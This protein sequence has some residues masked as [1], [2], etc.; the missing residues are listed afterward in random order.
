MMICPETFYEMHLKGKTKEEIMTVI[1]GLKREIGRLKRTMEH[2]N[3]AKAIKIHPSE[4]VRISCSRDYLRRA[5]EALEEVGGTYTP[6]A[7]EKK[8]L[9]FDSNIPYINKV[10][11]CIGGFLDGY[12]RIIYTIDGDTVHTETDSPFDP[13]P[14]FGEDEDEELSKED[15]LS[16]LEEMHIGEWLKLYDC[17][18]FG[19]HILDGTQWHLYLYFSNGHRPVKIYGNND[20]PYNFYRLLDLFHLDHSYQ[21]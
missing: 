15:I 18:R 4:D 14:I 20:Y 9:G 2:P 11:F 8:A 10:E 1:R 6:S 19:R 17:K 21:N 3:Y 12:R 5:I 16:S 13:I 7:A